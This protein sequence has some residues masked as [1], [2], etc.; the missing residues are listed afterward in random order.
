MGRDAVA[1]KVM[2][3]QD[4]FGVRIAQRNPSPAETVPHSL[5][6]IH[7][8][9]ERLFRFG[10][11]DF[12]VSLHRAVKSL[13]LTHPE[14]ASVFDGVFAREDEFNSSLVQIMSI[15]QYAMD[16][17][18]DLLFPSLGEAFMRDRFDKGVAKKIDKRN[19]NK[20]HVRLLRDE[21]ERERIRLSKKMQ[22]IDLQGVYKKGNEIWNA[23]PED[24]M[25]FLRFD[26]AYDGEIRKAE[27]KMR[28]YQEIGCSTLAEEIGRNIQNF[29]ETMEQTYY[30]FN[31][32][33]MTNAAIVLAK[34]HG[35]VFTPSSSINAGGYQTQTDPQ[36]HVERDFFSDYNFD[37]TFVI[38]GSSYNG[39]YK[40]LYE[41]KVYPFHELR[42]LA[43]G[44][45][46]EVIDRLENF[47]EA[48][49][50]PIFDHYGVIVPS[51]QYKLN[52]INDGDGIIQ[53]FI[54]SHEA[55]RT[56]DKI[57]I[58]KKI[59]YP[60]IVGERDGKCFFICHWD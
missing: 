29:V 15:V 25:S 36:I 14:V 2:R 33:T 9:S 7:D 22:V 20:C 31:R 54:E 50:K 35:F 48:N 46:M 34:M 19:C 13:D 40:H 5:S 58:E 27:R 45:T 57:L 28:R 47:P 43:S 11:G 55:S 53:N 24:F 32:I 60:V 21:E 39:V 30:G 59:I 41:P 16:S 18:L 8:T 3:A 23:Q 51:I 6:L 26:S 52:Y 4:E 38:L 10:F 12:G 44:R 56:L 1:Q 49:G 17:E 37:P 42:H